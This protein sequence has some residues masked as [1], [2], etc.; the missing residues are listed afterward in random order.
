MLLNNTPDV[1]IPQSIALL[2]VAAQQAFHNV[3]DAEEQCQKLHAA[4]DEFVNILRTAH[5]AQFP[6]TNNLMTLVLLL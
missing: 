1:E 2:P 4:H 6:L 3:E 5:R